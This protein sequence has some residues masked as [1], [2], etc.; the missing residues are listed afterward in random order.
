M[1][2][3]IL[4]TLTQLV[5]TILTFT[6]L[7]SLLNDVVGYQIQYF[8]TSMIGTFIPLLIFNLIGYGIII[9]SIK[10]INSVNPKKIVIRASLVF[11][12]IISILMLMLDNSSIINYFGIEFTL[13][14]YFGIQSVYWIIMGLILSMYFIRNNQVELTVDKE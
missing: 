2:T 4:S 7:F 14:Q 1:K 6:I 12:L 13:I 8:A 11:S 9:L 10:N 3:L 5:T